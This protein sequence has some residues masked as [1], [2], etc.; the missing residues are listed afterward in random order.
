M[1][2]RVL[3]ALLALT[4]VVLVADLAGAPLGPLREAGTTVIGPVQRFLAPGDDEAAALKEDNIRLDEQVRRLEEERRTAATV[5][6]LPTEGMETV[7]AR[8]VSLDRAGASG[9]ERV[10]LDA[11]RRDGLQVDRAVLAPGG[12]VGRVVEV[13]DSTADVEVIGSPDARVG[14][15]TGDQGVIGTLTGSDPTTGHDA[16]E[17]VVTQLGRDRAEE[18]DEVVTIGSPGQRPYPPGI[19]VGSV[20]SVG[21]G[22]G[23]LTDTALVEPAVDLATL[24]VVAVV[25]GPTRT[26]GSGR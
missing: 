4:L 10:T 6:E 12:L 11:G 20:T 7:T 9:P 17:L 5:D 23:Q 3:P 24:D 8:V 16:D 26:G 1:R 22:P 21:R 13:S 14:V 18:D 25:T 2:R 19:P 15:R